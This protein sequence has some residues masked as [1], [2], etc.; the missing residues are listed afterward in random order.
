MNPFCLNIEIVTPFSTNLIGLCRDQRQL[1]LI[2]QIF[3][4]LFYFIYFFPGGQSLHPRVVK[5]SIGGSLRSLRGQVGFPSLFSFFPELV[6]AAR[7]KS[8]V[9][10]LDGF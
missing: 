1:T 7:V 9:D 2:Y 8:E 10:S 6:S 5:R 3:Y 4:F